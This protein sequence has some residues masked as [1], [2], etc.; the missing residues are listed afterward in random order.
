MYASPSNQPCMYSSLIGVMGFAIGLVTVMQ[1]ET[2]PMLIMIVMVEMMINVDDRDG[3]DDDDY[4]DY[5][6]D[7]PRQLLVYSQM[8]H[9]IFVFIPRHHHHHHP[10]VG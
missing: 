8:F 10:I 1:V 7:K 4:D 3:D 2:R 9:H 6:Y 5:D